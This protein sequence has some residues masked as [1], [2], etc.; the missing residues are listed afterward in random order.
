[1]DVTKRAYAPSYSRM[2]SLVWDC[3]EGSYLGQD[4]ASGTHDANPTYQLE[5]MDDDKRIS[6]AFRQPART[7]ANSVKRVCVWGGGGDFKVRVPMA[8]MIIC[9]KQL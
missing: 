4:T 2:S 3:L 9:T 8:Q 1:M 7:A 5:I 6:S